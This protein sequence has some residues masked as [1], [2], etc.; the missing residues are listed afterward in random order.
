M[1]GLPTITNGAATLCGQGGEARQQ[2]RL[3]QQQS[4]QQTDITEEGTNTC[5]C[6]EK[7]RIKSD[8]EKASD[9]TPPNKEEPEA[10]E[11]AEGR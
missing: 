5:T 9:P 3:I 8:E 6:Q 1:K 2:S 10:E 7:R 11:A 4:T